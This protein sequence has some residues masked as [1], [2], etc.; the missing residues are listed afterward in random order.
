M[1]EFAAL[2][3]HGLDEFCEPKDNDCT[4]KNGSKDCCGKPNT[5]TYNFY[6]PIY[7]DIS[8]FNN[9]HKTDIDADC[10]EDNSNDDENDGPNCQ[11]FTGYET[12]CDPNPFESKSEDY[13]LPQEDAHEPSCASAFGDA[14]FT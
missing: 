8:A 11:E 10:D 3:D 13:M 14:F 7:G 4:C 2:F 9:E 12:N 5:I 1:L 6:G